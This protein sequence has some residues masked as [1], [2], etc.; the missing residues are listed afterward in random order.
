MKHEA[1]LE[2]NNTALHPCENPEYIIPDYS[3]VLK[4]ELFLIKR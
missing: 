1:E 3:W 2:N 4:L